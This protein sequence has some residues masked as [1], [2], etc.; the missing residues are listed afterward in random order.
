MD[1]QGRENNL[2]DS[3][4]IQRYCSEG[5]E[6]NPTLQQSIKQTQ[7]PSFHSFNNVTSNRN[8][9]NN[10]FG[11][12]QHFKQTHLLQIDHK[13]LPPIHSLSHP[14]KLERQHSSSTLSGRSEFSR[15]YDSNFA[16]PLESSLPPNNIP[17]VNQQS[18]VLPLQSQN[19]QKI[20]H[21]NATQDTPNLAPN[22]LQNSDSRYQLTRNDYY[23]GPSPQSPP[24]P[25]TTVSAIQNA[26]QNSSGFSSEALVHLRP[27]TSDSGWNDPP[28]EL[29]VKD[30]SRK[31]NPRRRQNVDI[32][33]LPSSTNF[34]QSH[35]VSPY[36]STGQSIN[37]STYGFSV[38]N[39]PLLTQQQQ[40]HMQPVF[41]HSNGEQAS[42][43]YPT[44]PNIPS[45]SV[46]NALYST[47][48]L[49]Q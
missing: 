45:S 6:I 32:Y 40:T 21:N 9:Q 4:Y 8:Y 5:N 18:N 44:R 16:R 25:A 26:Q 42:Y 19:P 2:N 36:S 49:P 14:E 33:N 24:F 22:I 10:D 3:S 1:S 11:S 41:H 23:S 29:F 30:I 15:H 48:N 31:P 12:Q 35:T 34:L 13:N 37:S 7:S 39:Y 47:S 46:Q 38:S 20:I 28:P 17:K 27:K 43:V